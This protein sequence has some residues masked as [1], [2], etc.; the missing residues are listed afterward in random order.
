MRGRLRAFVI[1]HA[2]SHEKRADR[3]QQKAHGEQAGAW[4]AAPIAAVAV[5]S[6]PS[7]AIE[8]TVIAR[9]ASVRTAELDLRGFKNG[10]HTVIR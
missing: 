6:A 4:N 3:D 2:D 5:S 1:S 9:T 7:T 8:G 10:R